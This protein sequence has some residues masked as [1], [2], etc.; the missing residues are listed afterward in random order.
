MFQILA[1]LHMDMRTIEDC[2]RIRNIEKTEEASGRSEFLV[3]V[4]ILTTS[5][6]SETLEKL[7][8]LDRI[9]LLQISCFV[10]NCS[11][12]NRLGRCNT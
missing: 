6:L 8:V 2:G 7:G 9:I 4:G 5:K 3:I 1:M 12:K 10:L 11:C